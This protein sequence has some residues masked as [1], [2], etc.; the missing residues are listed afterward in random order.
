[1]RNILYCLGCF[2]FGAA[3]GLLDVLLVPYLGFWGAFAATAVITSVGFGTYLNIMQKKEVQ[4][5][6]S[7]NLGPA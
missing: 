3:L 7:L 4:L 2:L 1:M 6:K 5:F